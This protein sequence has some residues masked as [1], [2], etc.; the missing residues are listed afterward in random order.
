MLSPFL[1]PSLKNT[2]PLSSLPLL[3]NPATPA[4]WPWHS[5]HIES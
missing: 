4:S 1:V 3:T 2:F 5:P